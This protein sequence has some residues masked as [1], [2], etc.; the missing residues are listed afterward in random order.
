V[1]P[2]AGDANAIFGIEERMWTRMCFQAVDGC[3]QRFV[4]AILRASAYV[5]KSSAYPNGPK[6][7]PMM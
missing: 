7:L 1:K 5:C 3:M 4:R 2:A 6:Y